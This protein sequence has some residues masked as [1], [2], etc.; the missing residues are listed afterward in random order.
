LNITPQEIVL[1]CAAATVGAQEVGANRGAYVDRIIRQTGLTP[2]QPWCACYVCD[3]GLAALGSQWPVPKTASCYLLGEWAKGNATLKVG[4]APGAIFLIYNAGLK[5]FAHTGFCLQGN[6]TVSGNTTVPGQ[7]GDPREGWAVARK[8]WKF[9]PEDRF[10][11][12]WEALT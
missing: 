1:R 12:W 5:R 3:V 7:I 8:P 4:P 9:K 10:V 6:D 11:Y 2:P